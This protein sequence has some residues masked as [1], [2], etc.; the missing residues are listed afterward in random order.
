MNPAAPQSWQLVLADLALILFL[1]TLSGLAGS[2]TEDVAGG[3]TS[4]PTQEPQ[5]APSQALFRPSAS[6]PDLREWLASQP[7]DHRSTLTIYAQY[8]GEDRAAAWAAAQRLSAQAD[9]AGYAVRIVIAR[10]EE[11]D[12]YASLAYDAPMQPIRP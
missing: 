6:G 7:V 11:S 8:Q 4:S 9:E 3:K 12:L 10:G 1:V 2:E 5:F